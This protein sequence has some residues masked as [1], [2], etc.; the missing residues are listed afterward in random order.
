MAGQ[1]ALR[2]PPVP[3]AFPPSSDKEIAMKH[4][5]KLAA[6]CAALTVL[7]V[8]PARADDGEAPP[9]PAK[10]AGAERQQDRMKRCNTEAGKK[11]LKGDERR[12]YMSTC[13]KG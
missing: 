7:L 10:P 5:T 13:L 11:A 9:S 8:S 12:A 1:H 2:A 3:V 4:R 6:A